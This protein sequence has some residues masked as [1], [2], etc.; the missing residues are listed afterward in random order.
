VLRALLIGI[1]L[2]AILVPC[3]P[4]A[5]TTQDFGAAAE[6]APIVGS[7]AH[8]PPLS[9]AHPY[10]AGPV[11]GSEIIAFRQ[12]GGY[13]ADIRAVNARARAYVTTWIDRHCGPQAD[14]A[15]VRG[16]RAMLVSDIDDTLI[17]WYSHYANP[18]IDFQYNP[19]AESIAKAGCT[20]PAIRQTV[21]LVQYA[22]QRG[23]TVALMSGRTNAERAATTA[24]LDRIGITGYR[25][26]ILRSPAEAK[27]SAQDYKSHR[28]QLLERAGWRIMLSIGDQ[29]SDMLGGSTDAGFLLPN[30]MYLIP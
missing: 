6:G 10:D 3:A 15:Q 22:Q 18:A 29:P 30:P 26:L 24:C 12:S 4:A 11:V 20:P 27:L 17:S 9:A 7:D 23:V 14:A 2:L 25:Y 8:L 13:Q 1:A 21:A 28:R 16:C 5:V 19:T